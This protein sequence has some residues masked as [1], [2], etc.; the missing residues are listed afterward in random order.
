VLARPIAHSL[1]ST[2][3]LMVIVENNGAAGCMPAARSVA[4]SDPD[5]HTLLLGNT[6]AVLFNRP[7][8]G[9][10]ASG[11]K[12]HLRVRSEKARMAGLKP[13]ARNVLI[14]DQHRERHQQTGPQNIAVEISVS[15][16]ATRVSDARGSRRA[17]AAFMSNP[18]NIKFSVGPIRPVLCF[19]FISQAPKR[20]HWSFH[21]L[22]VVAEDGSPVNLRVAL[23][24]RSK[25]STLF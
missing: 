21:V 5:G 15:R 23:R 6:C 17:I 24:I 3:A 19:I 12:A 8:Q 25:I 20:L 18:P 16:S 22:L 10:A 14:Q 4:H 13:L 9:A 2:A 7:V 1:R 11:G